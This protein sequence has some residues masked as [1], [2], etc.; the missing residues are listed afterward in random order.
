[1]DI[2]PQ[3]DLFAGRADRNASLTRVTKNSGNFMFDAISVF[4][5]IF[6]SNKNMK[7]SY[8]R[9]TGE[10]I[11]VALTN[12]GVTPH[13]PNAWGA[14]TRTLILRGMLIP[15]SEFRHMKSRRSHARMTRVYEVAR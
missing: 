2:H 8:E 11:R 15:T 5:R 9:V 12:W 7:Y 14:L 10:D 13:H 6:L 4:R 1:M 3:M